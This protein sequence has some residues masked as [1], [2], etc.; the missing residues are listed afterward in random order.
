MSP[1]EALAQTF[2]GT[3]TGNTTWTAA[4]SPIQVTGN[5]L[6]P[7]G[8]TLTI[9]PGVTVQF[10]AGVVLR[11]DGTLVARGTAAAG[12]VFTSSQASATPGFWGRVAFMDAAVDAIYDGSGNYVSGS[13]LEHVI[14][15]G[16][17]AISDGLAIYI[18]DTSPL[19]SALTLRNNR[20]LGIHASFQPTLT[21]GVLKILNCEIAGQKGGGIDLRYPNHVVLVEGNWI[22]DGTNPGSYSYGIRLSAGYRM[23][24]NTATAVVRGNTITASGVPL[25][26]NAT[27]S[28]LQIVDNLISGGTRGVEIQ[29]DHG[30]LRPEGFS[31]GGGS[32]TV[33]GNTIR[34]NSGRGLN[35]RVADTTLVVTDNVITQNASHVGGAGLWI[36]GFGPTTI[37]RNIISENTSTQGSH[38][39]AAGG[40]YVNLWGTDNS[41]HSQAPA[42]VSTFSNNLVS[43][44][45]SPHQAAGVVSATGTA[46][47]AASGNTFTGNQT[48]VPGASMLG[49]DALPAE[50]LTF[51]G[52]NLFGNAG[53][54]AV[55][56]RGPRF[57]DARN[58]WW[59]TTDP[60]AIQALLYDFADDGTLGP[61]DATA[62]LSTPAMA[63][64]VSPVTGLTVTPAAGSVT[65]AW[66]ANPETDVSGYRVWYGGAGGPPYDGTGASEGNSPIDVGSATSVTLSSVPDGVTTITVTAYD[67]DRDGTADLTDGNESW[68]ARAQSVLVNALPAGAGRIVVTVTRRAGGSAFSGVLVQFLGGPRLIVAE[69]LTN[70]A[71]VVS[72]PPLPPGNYYVQTTATPDYADLW[73]P[74]IPCEPSFDCFTLS[75]VAVAAGADTSI[76]FALARTGS[77]AGTITDGR[78]NAVVPGALVTVFD[79]T[80]HRVGG[81]YTGQT[82]QYLIEYLPEGQYALSVSAPSYLDVVFNSC[83]RCH[84]TQGSLLAISPAATTTIDMALFP[85]SGG[86]F[87]GFVRDLSGNPVAGVTVQ[88]R[89]G[90]GAL[91]ASALTSSS[92]HYVTAEVPTGAYTITTANDLGYADR[93]IVGRSHTFG[94]TG[95]ITNF[96]LSRV[97][98]GTITAG[99]AALAGARVEIYNSAGTVIETVLSDVTGAYESGAVPAGMYFVKARNSAGYA[100]VVYDG[101]LCAPEPSC[102]VDTVGTPIIVG[103]GLVTGGV[104]IALVAPNTSVGT[105]VVV[106]PETTSGTT[107]IRIAFSQVAAA[108]RTTLAVGSSGSIPP[109]GFELGDPP[110]YFNLASTATWTSAS[111]CINYAG[112]G[113][114][115]P[116]TLA[117]L[118]FENGAWVD[119]TSSHDLG[120][121]T[122][123]GT[124]TSFSPFAVGTV[125]PPATVT[126]VSPVG[127]VESATPTYRWQAVPG[128]TSYLLWV[129][130]T[131]TKA[132]VRQTVTPAQA[133]CSTTAVCTVTP[134]TELA[135]GPAT[136]WVQ[137][138]NRAGASPW[139]PGVTITVA[140]HAPAIPAHVSPAGAVGSARPTYVW[141]ALPGVTSYY[142]W[143]NDTRTKA[144]VRQMYS[145][146][147]AA[148]SDPVATPLCRA[149]PDAPLAEGPAT[150]WVQAFKGTRSS[151]WGTGVGITVSLRPPAVA[152]ISPAEAA[153]APTKPTYTWNAVAGAT[154]YFLW[155]NDTRTKAAVRQMYTAAEAGCLATAVCRATPVTPL[156]EGPATWWVQAFYGALPGPWGTGVG[157]TVSERPTAVVLIGPAGAA[158]AATMPTYAWN[159]VPGATDYFLWVNDTRTKAAVR[160]MYTAAEAGCGDA[161]TAPTCQVTPSTALAR[162]PATW[163]VQAFNGTGP[164]PWGDGLTITIP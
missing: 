6:V 122:I 143:V 38:I 67:V 102:D 16:A 161:V 130:D 147:E 14:I 145:A 15:E 20:G 153:V 159:A 11:V 110:T 24:G 5:L 154:D 78:S 52:N 149:T 26:A 112:F 160:Q 4:S 91:V 137:T 80:G 59:G 106:V 88:V 61:I 151:P 81:A 35:V 22:H 64:P 115:N 33:D 51:N 2:S 162:G 12:I 136:W 8:V 87:A 18:N 107:P 148:C 71:G 109:S 95:T 69:G 84:P 118:H 43:H 125:V 68:Y 132:A 82:G 76:A 101:I 86:G 134:S 164:G 121:A 89:S 77:L 60:D 98:G 105:N 36:T 17:G 131:R 58:N 41:D 63:P 55:N 163:W 108:G 50:A 48:T 28:T 21:S 30:M 57:I 56:N 42:P 29:V 83:V 93:S 13:V 44:N 111:V 23:I 120:T 140:I 1:S 92:G 49:L 34:N 117:L 139:G 85:Q 103:A 138:Y 54:Y 116:S 100:N 62:P 114:G 10:A 99:G 133:G 53:S 119:A 94:V 135:A 45:I 3:L 127:S 128:V 97:I 142:L 25:E 155:V 73:Y 123:C 124:V 32:I 74:D 157:I 9:Q 104:A 141:E 40:V 156:A 65:L 39:Q 79:P 113:V 144:A 90:A 66:S 37:S 96:E 19:L 7:S 72:S 129:N 146:A 27:Q 126:L 152:L 158:V 70:A 46:V 150:W 47:L 75:P 31:S